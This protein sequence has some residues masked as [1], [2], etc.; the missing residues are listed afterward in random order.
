MQNAGKTVRLIKNTIVELGLDSRIQVMEHPKCT[1]YD[2]LL[3][4]CEEVC[5]AWMLA[6][7]E[8]DVSSLMFPMDRLMEK[9][10]QIK[11]ILK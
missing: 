4:I 8:K 11:G 2:E 6:T 10:G 1:N 7:D 3:P 5:R 9:I